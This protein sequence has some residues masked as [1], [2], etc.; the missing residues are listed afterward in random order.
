MENLNIGIKGRCEQIVTFND[1]AAKYGSGLLP[2][3]ATPALIALM[4][5]TSMGSVIPYLEKSQNTVG[6]EVNVKHLKATPI[7]IKVTCE[8]ELIKIDGN[9]LYFNVK[10]SDNEGE[11]GIGSHTRFI[12]DTEKF[13]NKFIGIIA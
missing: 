8:S 6:T 10:V 12:V 4:E 2:V 5:K 11:I 3:F 1:T 9:K 13:M 7:G